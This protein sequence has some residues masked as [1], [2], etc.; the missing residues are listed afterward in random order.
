M[1]LLDIISESTEVR[2]SSG[3]I[4]GVVT[5][6][7]TNIE[8]PDSMG[9]VK[10]MIPRMTGQSDESAWA[11]VATFMAGPGRGAFFLPEVDDEVLLAFEYGDPSMPYVI[12][13]LWNGQDAPPETN[14]DGKNDIRVIKSRSGHKMI[15]KFQKVER[16]HCFQ[17]TYLL[18][19]QFQYLY[20]SL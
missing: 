5:G 17:Y 18:I 4:F 3:H 9:R 10:V 7:V 11:R 8:D 1:N 16:G 2:K 15:S 6:V 20:D 12:G 14:S 13:A 19:E